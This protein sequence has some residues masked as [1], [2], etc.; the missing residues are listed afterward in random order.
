VK[1]IA[2][3]QA[4]CPTTRERSILPA[5]A[6]PRITPEG[7]HWRALH[8][9]CVTNWD[10]LTPRNTGQRFNLGPV[11]ID[12]PSVVLRISLVCKAMRSGCRSPDVNDILG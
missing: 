9:S 10:A 8:Q 11:V 6:A 1:F 12:R 5:E 3:V 2:S 7:A 4:R